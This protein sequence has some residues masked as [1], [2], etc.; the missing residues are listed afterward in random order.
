MLGLWLGCLLAWFQ[1]VSGLVPPHSI[2]RGD[3]GRG[4]SPNLSWHWFFS[5]LSPGPRGTNGEALTVPLESNQDYLWTTQ[6]QIGT[7][8]VNFTVA[9]DT[10]SA[11]MWIDASV[12]NTSASQTFATANQNFS[13]QY[14]LG[15]VSG[16]VC[17]DN[18]Q[19]QSLK[20]EKQ[21]FGIATNISG[22]NI[23]DGVQ[24]VMGMASQGLSQFH[25]K[26][27]WQNLP[28]NQSL[29]SLYLRSA[30]HNRSEPPSSDGVL[31]LGTMDRNMF[32]DPLNYLPTANDDAWSVNF[33]GINVSNHIIQ[34]S[35]DTNALIDSG[36][37]LIGGPR[38]AIEEFYRQ[39][40]GA[41]EI[42]DEPGFFSFPCVSIPDVHLA[43]GNAQYQLKPADLILKE[44]RYVPDDQDER[45]DSDDF[46]CIGTFFATDPGD[47]WMIGGTFL[48]N[49]YTVF[50]QGT[51]QIGFAP[52]DTP[53]Y[54]SKSLPTGLPSGASFLF[55]TF[56]LFASFV[57][58][59]SLLSLWFL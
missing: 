37:V 58:I 2:T 10:G 57:V 23:P 31:S 20:V 32:S 12:F 38:D 5:N 16:Y 56:W 7:P 24:G 55:P 45:P 8:P 42:D 35:A 47:S 19:L 13:I 50:N 6:I 48:K 4:I 29:F 28:L 9:V 40:D 3:Q 25:N 43:F 18:V 59:A 1:L 54:Q 44:A 21:V 11:D 53:S 51:R 34:V 27:F 36:T 30:D 52:L 17:T 26:P 49:V 39:F 41:S 33:S 22:T 15:K 46:K 14:D